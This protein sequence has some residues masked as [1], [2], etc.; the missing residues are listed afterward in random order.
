MIYFINSVYDGRTALHIAAS[1]GHFEIVKYLKTCCKCKLNLKDR[2]G[3]TA[4][5][6]ARN[7]K[8][9]EVEKLLMS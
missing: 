8:H 9:Y 1:E 7:F 3:N 5:D 6:D 2:F 4:I